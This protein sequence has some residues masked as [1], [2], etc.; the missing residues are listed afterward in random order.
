MPNKPPNII[1]NLSEDDIYELGKKNW[2]SSEEIVLK[3]L[4]I[5]EYQIKNIKAN[6]RWRFNYDRGTS[7]GIKAYNQGLTE[8]KD[9]SIQKEIAKTTLKPVEII[10]EGYE[11][12]IDAPEWF[13][14]G[15]SKRK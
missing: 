14:K 1:I 6:K 12:E 3:S 5:K 10:E 4:G 8:S 2:N 13:K 9:S 15:I 7:E 11:F